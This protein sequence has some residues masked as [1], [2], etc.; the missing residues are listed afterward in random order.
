VTSS[1]PAQGAQ[2][3]STPGPGTPSSSPSPRPNGR[4]SGSTWR[5]LAAKYHAD[6]ARPPAAGQHPRSGLRNG[7]DGADQ[8]VLLVVDAGAEQQRAGAAGG[9]GAELQRP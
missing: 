8:A 6:A 3:R 2:D 5:E 4:Q 1:P 9:R 7:V